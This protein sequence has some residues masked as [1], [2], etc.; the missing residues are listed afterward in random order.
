MFTR[1]LLVAAALAASVQAI[2]AQ[3]QVHAIGA[4]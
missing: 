4:G 1:T 2:R 3:A